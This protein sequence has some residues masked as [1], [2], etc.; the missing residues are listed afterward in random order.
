MTD[1]I[2]PASPLQEAFA[3]YVKKAFEQKY[4]EKLL[5]GDWRILAAARLLKVYKLTDDN[6]GELL[7]HLHEQHE[8]IKKHPITRV[9]IR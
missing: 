1:P 6:A 5:C 8:F 3:E 9:R 7:D 4:N 2:L